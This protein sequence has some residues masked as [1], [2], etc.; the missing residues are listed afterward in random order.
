MFLK[1]FKHDLKDIGKGMLVI[2][3]FLLATALLTRIF[4][5]LGEKIYLF[6]DLKMATTILFVISCIASF[7]YCF[8]LGIQK[9]HQKVLKDQGYLTN[10]LP[11]KKGS[12]L[13]S[14]LIALNFMMVVTLGVIILGIF[15]A[16]FEKEIFTAIWEMAKNSVEQ[17]GYSIEWIL[18]FLVGIFLLSNISLSS[19]VICALVMGHGFSKNKMGNSIGIGIILYVIYQVLNTIGVVILFLTT[20]EILNQLEQAVPP[21]YILEKVFSINIITMLI[22]IIGT[23]Y[24]AHHSLKKRLNLE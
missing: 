23:N 18:V 6:N 20:P 3:L 10:T 13:A 2:Y 5:M 24:F 21:D 1:L 19:S 8:I 14:K 7:V 9:F 17:V 4:G 16:Y 12:I 22:L 15:F 11:V